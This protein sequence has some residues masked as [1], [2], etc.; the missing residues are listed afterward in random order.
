MKKRS[1]IDEKY[2]WDLSRFVKDDK[3]VEDIMKYIKDRI[4]AVKKYYGKLSDKQMLLNLLEEDEKEDK[5]TSRLGFF[6]YNMLQVDDSNTKYLKYSQ[7]CDVLSQESAE[8]SAFVYP[9]MLELPDEYLDELINDKQLWKYKR[10]FTGIKRDKAHKLSEYDAQFLSKMS[11]CLGNDSEVYETLTTS[12]IQFEDALDSDGNK[13]IVN[14][15]EMAKLIDS[16]DRT[17]RKNAFKSMRKG[18]AEKNKTITQLYINDMRLCD[19]NRKLRRFN[20]YKEWCLYGEEIPKIVYDKLIE[21]INLRVAT[22][23]EMVRLRKKYL[24]YD[25]VAYWDIIASVG[26]DKTYTVEQ[27][28]QWIKECTKILGD[29]Y[30]QLL[31]EKFE[32]KVIDYLPNE[33]KQNGG[34]SWSIYGYPSVICMNFVD[35]FDSVSTLS[36]EIGHAIHSEFSNKNQPR[37]LADYNIIVAEEASTVNQ[38][39]LNLHVRKT[40]TKEENLALIFEFLDNVSGTI[41]KQTLFSEFEDFAHSQIEQ[42]NPITYEDLNNKYYE[43]NKKYYGESIELPEELKYDWSRI[44]HFYTP[45]YVYKYATGFVSALCI[46]QNLLEDSEYYKKYINFLKSG[47]SK[48][49]VELLQDIDVDL[50]TDEPYNKAFKFV[51]NILNELK[52]ILN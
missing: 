36:H 34:Y 12:E 15:A 32:Q 23:Q 4:P 24:G 10:Y 22:F 14:H 33:N 9:Q 21:Q 29:E 50:T 1:E 7:M 30:Q 17:L 49:S 16:P 27:A 5:Y 18:Y 43:L 28:I 2:K 41:F 52:Q 39:L 44:P 45:F 3:D 19:F 51:D 42:A 8:A 20:S 13:H 25:D 47:C 31:K 35:D 38:I 48:P 40:A 46:V 26:N 11:L 6:L 37:Q